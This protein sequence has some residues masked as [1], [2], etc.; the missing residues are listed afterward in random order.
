MNE[1]HQNEMKLIGK[2]SIVIKDIKIDGLVGWVGD[3]GK[4]LNINDSINGFPVRDVLEDGVS[5]ADLLD[6]TEFN[7]IRFKGVTL[8]VSYDR[9]PSPDSDDIQVLIGL[10]GEPF[11]DITAHP[12]EW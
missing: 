7:L 8:K 3:F 6:E 9:K 4:S 2:P 5:T 10:K 11:F 12:Y 1:S